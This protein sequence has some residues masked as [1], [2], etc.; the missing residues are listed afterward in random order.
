VYI[1][2]LKESIKKFFQ[3]ILRKRFKLKFRSKKDR[4]QSIVIPSRD[5]GRKH[6]EFSFLMGI[7][8]SEQ[9]PEKME[10][11]CRLTINRLGE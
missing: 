1:R 3:C 9:I 7:K 8:S 10:Y 4:L 11:D 2:G 5:W 6:G